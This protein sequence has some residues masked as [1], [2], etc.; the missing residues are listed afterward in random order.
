MERKDFINYNPVSKTIRNSLIPT[1][2]TLKNIEETGVLVSDE[3]RAEVRNVLKKIMDDYYKEYINMCLSREIKMDWRPLFDAYELVKKGKMKPKE[4][5]NIQD[6]KRKEIYDILSAHDE[7]KKMFSAKMITELLPQFIF[8]ST[9]YNEDEKK[10]Y[11]EVIHIYSRFTSDFTDFFQNRKNV[12]SS[13]GIATSICNR[14][15]NENAEIFSDNKST[16]DRI[17]KDISCTDEIIDSDLKNYLDGWELEQIYS[18]DFYSRLMNQGGIDFYNMISG[19]VNKAVNEY[20]QKNSLNKNKYLLR[21]LRKQILS[22]SE[23]TFQIPEKFL[24]DEEVYKAVGQFIDNIKSKN[25]IEILKDIGSNCEN[26]DLRRIYIAESAYEDVSIFMGYGWN[27]IRG[28]LKKKYEKEIAPGKAKEIKIKK[29]ISQE[30]ERSIAE[31]DELFH[32]YGEEKDGKSAI[33]YIEEVVELCNEV[34]TSLVYDS[35]EKLTENDNKAAE[36]KN[37]LDY[38]FRVFHWIKTFIT[39][40]ILD[41]DIMFYSGIEFA[42]EEIKDIV[43]LYNKVRNY[44]TQKPYSS[45]KIKL[46]FGT[47]TL[48]NGWSKSKE[49]DNNAILLVRDNKYY[50]GIFNVLNKPDK[51]IMAGYTNKKNSSDYAKMVYN[52]LP[53]PSKMLPKVCLSQKG[54]DTYHPSA[55]IVDNYERKAHVKSSEHF[56][57][58]YCHDLIDYFKECIKRNDDWKCFDFKFSDTEQYNDISEFYKEVELQGYSIGWTYISGEDIEALDKEGKLY[59]FQIYNKDFSEQSHGTDN[60]HTMYLKNLFSP[61]NLN[62]I[63]LKLNGEAELFY[64]KSSIKKPV[65]HK[66]GSILV[67]K[68]YT[69]KTGNGE[70]VRRPVPDDVYLE[71]VNYYNGGQKAILSDEAKKYMKVVEHHEAVKDIIKD[72]RYT[73]NKFFIHLPITINFKAEHTG[74]LNEMVI[75][76]IAKQENMHVIGID[77]GE[78]NLIYVSVIDMNGK[79]KE[80]KSFNIVNSYNYQEKLRG[81]EKDRLNARKNWKQ[82]ANI[83]EMKEGYLSLVIHEITEMMMKYNAIIAMEDLNYGF[84]RG[85]FKVER[86]V[87]QKF[88]TMLISKLNYLVDKHKKVDEPGGLLRGY[89]FAYVPASLDR[90]GRQCGFI[91]YVPAAYTSKIDPTTGF[92][93]LFNHS[94]LIKAGKR[95]DNLSKFDGIYYDEQKDMFCYAFDYKNFVTHNTDIYQNSWEIY[96]NKERLRKIFENGRPTGKTEKIELTQMMKEVL[97][98]AGVEYK[99]GHNLIDDIL[100]S[101]DNCIKQ[102][103]DIFL[104][105]IQLRNSKGENEDSKESDYDRIISPVLNQE[106]EFFDSVVYAD[107]YKK[108]EKLADKPIDADANGAYCIALKGLYEILQIKNNWKEGEVFSRD[109]LKITNADWLRFM[110]SRGFEQWKI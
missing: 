9:G 94:E 68:T 70:E 38:Y 95:R 102:V 36:I 109:T 34:P 10:Q 47:P 33:Q 6:E 32:V 56:S 86:Q 85:R 76:Y 72:Y 84:K 15:V 29:L 18:V 71:L 65:V 53:G 25:V 43:P 98:G 22:N 75:Q 55:Y 96:T 54:K 40:D 74:N 24:A 19:V 35:S 106:N 5:E 107:K 7:F 62:N 81:R 97:T 57:I 101:N 26:Y 73:V 67:N 13:A 79:I 110:Q 48:A 60:L 58:Q 11:E 90:L 14:I 44:V 108:D 31:I 99:D 12:F 51:K 17:K 23:S 1:E 82:I 27:G 59:L 28:C 77:R 91:F 103:L 87:Y 93:D 45:E 39:D 66:K 42:Y 46:K 83:K 49:F 30:K 89:Q 92:V 52:L 50:L 88:E 4:I 61:E 69:E 63:V 100:N 2:Y 21:K 8:Q 104:Y 78:R 20:C 16:F 80:Q 3:Y 41:K 64:R 105:S 37:A